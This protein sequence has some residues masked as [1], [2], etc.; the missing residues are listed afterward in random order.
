[1]Q[2]AAL[3]AVPGMLRELF[4]IAEPAPSTPPPEPDPEI[5]DD[6]IEPIVEPVETPFPVAPVVVGGVG[7]ALIGAGIALGLIANASEDEWKTADTDTHGKVDDAL[8]IES[9]AKLEATLSN[10]GFAVGGAALAAGV[11]WLALE[12][13]SEQPGER[14][15]MMLLPRLTPSTAGVSLHGS[16]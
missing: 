3:D 15:N 1:V 8:E 9:R 14:A 10:V 7:V 4:G 6:A 13:S 12:L 16:L 11:V 2:Q 5:E